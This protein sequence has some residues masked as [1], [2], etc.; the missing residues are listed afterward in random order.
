MTN[1]FNA[2]NVFKCGRKLLDRIGVS[3]ERACMAPPIEEY[4]TEMLDSP[5]KHNRRHGP[6]L[7][8]KKLQGAVIRIMEDEEK[9]AECN[10][11]NVTSYPLSLSMDKIKTQT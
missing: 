7:S 3:Y 4:F 1:Y 2:F 9:D 11:N 5:I 8:S 6:S 10:I